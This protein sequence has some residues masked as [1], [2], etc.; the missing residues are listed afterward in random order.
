VARLQSFTPGR[1]AAGLV[2]I[3][4]QTIKGI[5]AYIRW[6]EVEAPM[7]LPF[8]MNQLAHMMALTN[9]SFARKMAFGPYDPSERRPEQAWRTPAQGIRRISQGY[10]LGWRVRKRGIGHYILF[11]ASREAYFIEYGISEIG[12]GGNRAVPAR[13]IRR[14]VRKLSLLKTIEF[15]KT[16]NAYHRIWVEA[17]KTR[18]GHAGFNQIVQS[19][20]GGHARWQT[21]SE[22]EAL[23]VV[24][25]VIRAGQFNNYRRFVRMTPGGGWQ[26]RQ[27]NAGGGSF[28]GPPLGRKLP[29]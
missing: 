20:A 15:M 12:F 4:P 18:H 1:G 29:G 13:R 23:G 2:E 24:R 19:P 14:P 3:T 10:Y 25:R 21:V 9:Q 17:L 7:K 6:A 8:Y 26:I 22:H 16:T 27:K 5:E 11:N 28:R